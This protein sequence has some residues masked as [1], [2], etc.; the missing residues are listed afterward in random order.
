MNTQFIED[1]LAADA[2]TP[3]GRDKVLPHD[4]SALTAFLPTPDAMEAEITSVMEIKL[5]DSLQPWVDGYAKVGHRNR[6]LWNWCRRGVEVTML[7]C[8]DPSL[9]DAVCDTR[10]SWNHARRAF[11]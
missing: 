11:G 3:N 10:S 1:Q 6:F 9:Q 7:S 2:T 8:V 4:P 5:N